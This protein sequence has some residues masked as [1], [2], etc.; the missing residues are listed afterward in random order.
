MLETWR[1]VGQGVRAVACL[2]LAT[3]AITSVMTVVGGA[4]ATSGAGAVVAVT[5]QEERRGRSF[6]L[7]KKMRFADIICVKKR[8]ARERPGKCK[9]VAVLKATAPYRHSTPARTRQGNQGWCRDWWG[10]LRG[11]YY[12]NWKEKAKGRFCWIEGPSAPDIYR[13][14]WSCGYSSAIGYDVQPID[15]WDDRR[16]GDTRYGWWNSVYDKFRVS[17]VARGIPLHWTYQFHVNLHPTG[18]ISMYVDD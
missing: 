3:V 18:N 17:A 6:E 11:L 1:S 5:A 8:A 14:T 13:H 12:V 16:T 15:C 10:E 2:F 9:G 7:V 4:T